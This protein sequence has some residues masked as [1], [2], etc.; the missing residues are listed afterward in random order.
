MQNA[1]S[2][3]NAK[4]IFTLNA[5]FL[6]GENSGG[7]VPKGMSALFLPSCL[8]GGMNRFVT[9]RFLVGL[10]EVVGWLIVL[11]SCI[12]AYRTYGAVPPIQT[13]SVGAGGA[14][15]GLM[16]VLMCQLIR[17]QIATAL[18]TRDMLEEMRRSP[19]TAS[20]MQPSG[21]RR[22]EPTITLPP[23]SPKPIPEPTF[24]KPD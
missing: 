21:S 23:V 7:G 2:G 5:L 12:Y 20:T 17:A 15:V 3:V 24:D 22:L 4:C 18:N 16:V 10:Q 19:Q 1:F 14:G 9:A 13:V 8:E 11:G 6:A